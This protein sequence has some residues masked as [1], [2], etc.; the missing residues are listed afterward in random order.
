VSH[1]SAFVA[2][3]RRLR[4]HPGRGLRGDLARP[5]PAGQGREAD[6]LSP[7]PSRAQYTH[8]ESHDGCSL[9]RAARRL[10]AHAPTAISRTGCRS[11]SPIQ[12]QNSSIFQDSHPGRISVFHPGLRAALRAPREPTLSVTNCAL[13][14]ETRVEWTYRGGHFAITRA[15]GSHWLTLAGTPQTARR[16]RK[17]PLTPPPLPPTLISCQAEPRHL[18]PFRPG[19]GGNHKPLI[20]GYRLQGKTTSAF[21]PKAKVLGTGGE[22]RRT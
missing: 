1:H 22:R 4:S 18:N 13:P 12:G 3:R 14:P 17:N 9:S 19:R 6:T 5:T 11:P 20:T 2:V 8:G 16:R 15:A 7:T 10:H 21:A